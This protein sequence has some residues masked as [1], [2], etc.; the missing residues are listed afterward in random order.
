MTLGRRVVRIPRGSRRWHD[1]PLTAIMTGSEYNRIKIINTS[2][3]GGKRC[4]EKPKV[5]LETRAMQLRN[6][7]QCPERYTLNEETLRGHVAVLLDVV[8]GKMASESAL[9]LPER[10]L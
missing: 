1:L 5:T 2:N 4:S 9:R 7:L 10:K 3:E 8:T 6:W